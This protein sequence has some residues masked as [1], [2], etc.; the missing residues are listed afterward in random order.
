MIFPSRSMVTIQSS[1]V[2]T[3]APLSVSLWR[4]SSLVLSRSAVRPV[5]RCSNPSD[6][7]RNRPNTRVSPDTP[8]KAISPKRA[9]KF[10]MFAC[11]PVTV[12]SSG[13]TTSRLPLTSP[14]TQSDF[15]VSGCVL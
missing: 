7:R 12:M 9:D 15:G 4:N 1:A 11:I 3:I 6:V 5:T 10:H 13:K 2:S 14:S 8:S